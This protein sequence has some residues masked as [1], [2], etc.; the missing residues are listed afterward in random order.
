[1]L[2]SLPSQAGHLKKCVCHNGSYET[3]LCE[4]LTGSTPLALIKT[5]HDLCHK[6]PVDN[7]EHGHLKSLSAVIVSSR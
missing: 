3:R 4:R 7:A 2:F 5:V 1:M 6:S